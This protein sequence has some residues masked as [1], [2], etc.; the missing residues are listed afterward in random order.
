[1]NAQFYHYWGIPGN[2][3]GSIFTID[4][5]SASAFLKKL[6][7]NEK[8]YTEAQDFGKVGRK[9]S[10]SSKGKKIQILNGSKISGLAG[11]KQQELMAAGYTVPKIGDYTKE[12]LTQTRIIVTKDG[13][14][15]DLAAYFKEPDIV[16]GT[17]TEGFDI[18][19]ILGTVDA[20]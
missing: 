8:A 20:N 4:E 15:Q 11:S 16:V 17:V 9:K 13:M 2:F 10:I 1:M 18:E 12:V 3:S 7:K 6:E 19:I 14:G 5:A